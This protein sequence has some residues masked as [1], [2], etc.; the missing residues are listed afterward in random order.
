[1]LGQT[2]SNSKETTARRRKNTG[3]RK[4]SCAIQ[5]KKKRIERREGKYYNNF[6]RIQRH[7]EQKLYTSMFQI[8]SWKVKFWRNHTPVG[9]NFIAGN[10]C[11]SIKQCNAKNDHCNDDKETSVGKNRLHPTMKD[12]RRL[13][14][15]LS[16]KLLIIDCAGHGL[17]HTKVR[18]IS[19][20]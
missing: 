1:M 6:L 9:K 8:C 18:N 4:K 7:D 19:E 14:G 12:T 17:H 16:T 20:Y 2:F 13:W 11:S 3:R 5:K 15:G 10:K